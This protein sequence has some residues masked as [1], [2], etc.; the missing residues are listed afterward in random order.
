MNETVITGGDVT[1]A[2][3]IGIVLIAF[4]LLVIFV[5]RGQPSTAPAS[6]TAQLASIETRL[7]AVEAK[8]STTERTLHDMER[9]LAGL[10]TQKSVHEIEKQVIA[11]SGDVRAIAN[12][13]RAT[14]AAVGRVEEFLMKA[15]ADVLFAG[16]R[17]P[18][19]PAR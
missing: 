2:A 16:A 14:A 9:T 1:T 8:A 19:G 6:T 17:K 12:E 10:P 7:T 18:D 5:R 11:V 4:M 13:T 3:V 15:S